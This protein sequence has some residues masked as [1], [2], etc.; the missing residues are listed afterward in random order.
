MIAKYVIFYF[1][2][3]VI[4]RELLLYNRFKRITYKL[5]QR[6]FERIDT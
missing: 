1:Y 6:L 4:E 3:S 5:I 2:I